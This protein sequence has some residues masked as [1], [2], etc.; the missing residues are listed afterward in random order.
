MMLKSC[1]H[2][3]GDREGKGQGFN[4]ETDD[5]T[6]NDKHAEYSD[7]FRK[8]NGGWVSSEGISDNVGEQRQSKQC[9]EEGPHSKADMGK[10]SHFDRFWGVGVGL[11]STAW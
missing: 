8:V 3:I 9:P 6:K 11:R 2:N 10:R 5:S 4:K 7:E 1:C